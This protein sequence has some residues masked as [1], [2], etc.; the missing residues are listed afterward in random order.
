MIG[1]F[2]ASIAL[3]GFFYIA[4]TIDDKLKETTVIIH[5]SGDW[6]IYIK[7]FDIDDSDTSSLLTIKYRDEDPIKIFGTYC[8]VKGNCFYEFNKEDTFI[9]SVLNGKENVVV[10]IFDGRT[11]KPYTE[12]LF[13]LKFKK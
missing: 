11:I 10:D 3:I 5:K 9:V 8:F 2:F 12:T 4:F 1:L 7:N 13:H 6:Y